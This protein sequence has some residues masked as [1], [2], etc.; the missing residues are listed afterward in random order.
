MNLTYQNKNYKISFHTELVNYNSQTNK[1]IF[2]WYPNVNNY[3][4]CFDSNSQELHFIYAD[5]KNE[6]IK[7]INDMA[8]LNELYFIKKNN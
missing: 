2:V 8:I 3:S 7:L 5:S 4:I 1:E 6:L